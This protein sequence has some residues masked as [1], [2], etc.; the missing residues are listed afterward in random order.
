M[1]A[2][3][4]DR[5]WMLAERGLATVASML[6]SL[7]YLTI[8]FF[9]RE[10]LPEKW[11]TD[12]NKMLE[13]LVTGSSNFDDSF[14]ATARV[15][16]FFGP[17]YVNVVAASVGVA[18]LVVASS[19]VASLR[20]LAARWLFVLPCMLLNLLAPGKETVVIAM[21]II[22]VACG[23]SRSV[24]SRG[25]VVMSIV[26]YGC[27]ALFIRN[28]YAMILVLALGIRASARLTPAW[29]GVVLVCLLGAILVAPSEILYILQSPRD[30]SNNY[31]L[32][33]GSD[34]RTMIW[35]LYPPTSGVNFIVNYLYAAAMFVL[36][37]ISFRAPVD[38]AMML[39][40]FAIIRVALHGL[41]GTLPAGEEYRKRRWFATL[42]VAH[43]LVQFIFEPDLGS[44][45]RHL[46]SVSLFLIPLLTLPSANQD[47]ARRHMCGA[48]Q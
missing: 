4:L 42:I 8:Y 9:G 21:S 33:I 11:V 34:N 29:K 27:Y 20:D 44:Y 12:S 5:D 48:V 17:E 46:T 43:I 45:V 24:S 23:M 1:H 38:L 30:I 35:N 31:A 19:R 3:K 2:T 16:S 26:F 28:Y 37:V 10:S 7:L 15:F 36:P 6:L 13:F 14:A 22:L 39:M 18:Y 32:S 47:E 25:L 41:S 40:H